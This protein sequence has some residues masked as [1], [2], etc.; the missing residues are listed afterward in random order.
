M[1]L[2]VLLEILG[3]LESL[4][5]EIAF[6]WL[7]RNV[8]SNVGGNMVAFNSGSPALVPSTGEVQV[9]CA[10]ASDVLL[11]NVLEESLCR[12]AAL[13][14]FVPLTREVIIS[15]DIWSWRL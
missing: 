15:G 5:T 11:A 1:C 9:V 13:T 8:D 14:A 12:R 7:E 4:S 10:L 2:N 3:P 6:V